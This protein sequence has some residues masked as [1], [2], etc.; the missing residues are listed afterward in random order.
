MIAP[1]FVRFSIFCSIMAFS[2]ISRGARSKLLRSFSA[3]R[4]ARVI[5]VSLMPQ[6]I[7]ARVFALQGIIKV[8]STPKEPDEMGAKSSLSLKMLIFS[9]FTRSKIAPFLVESSYFSTI[10][11]P[12]LITKKTSPCG[13]NSAKYRANLIPNLTPLAPVMPTTNFLATNFLKKS[14][15]LFYENPQLCHRIFKKIL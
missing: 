8:D 9:H 10:F 15:F 12:S 5:S 1:I 4:A 3:T 6:A 14:P 13:T 7:L 11:A 2:G